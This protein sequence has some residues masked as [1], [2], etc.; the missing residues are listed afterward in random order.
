MSDPQISNS[1]EIVK[2][3]RGR[4]RINKDARSGPKIA[5]GK[6]EPKKWQPEYD[7]IV[8][9]SCI[10]YSHNDISQKMEKDYGIKY[11]PQHVCNILNTEAAKKVKEIIIERNRDTLFA[12]IETNLEDA[13]TKAAQRVKEV[14]ENDGLAASEPFKVGNFALKVLQGKGKVNS[15]HGAPSGGGNTT[16]INNQQNVFLSGESTKAL[17]EGLKLSME[18]DRIH[19]PLEE[20]KLIENGSKP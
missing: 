3:K 15:P 10:G 4:P 7:T 17:L 11:T 8:A 14:L 9:L 13:T 5:K 6:W 19:G 18:V 16:N 2:R 1:T 12:T 20:V